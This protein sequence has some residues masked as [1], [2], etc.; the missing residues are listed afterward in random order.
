MA[1]H[2]LFESSAGYALFAV[3]F[4]E[5]IAGRTKAVQ[6]SYLKIS[7]ISFILTVVLMMMSGCN[8]I[9]SSF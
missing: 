6:V 8:S 5:E 1:T 2:V 9:I 4:T 3:K 7:F